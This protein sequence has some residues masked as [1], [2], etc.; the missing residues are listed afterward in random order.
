MKCQNLIFNASVTDAST[1]LFC[2]LRGAESIQRE[3]RDNIRP[4]DKKNKRKSLFPSVFLKFQEF[5]FS[6]SSDVIQ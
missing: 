3:V 5:Q 4:Y 1:K 2:C 6:L